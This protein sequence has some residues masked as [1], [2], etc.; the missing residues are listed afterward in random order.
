MYGRWGNV[1]HAERRRSDILPA[2][3]AVSARREEI[4]ALPRSPS[5]AGCERSPEVQRTSMPA[6]T[7]RA[8]PVM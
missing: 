7:G 5:G 2:L 8:T 1:A 3:A 6:S 4:A